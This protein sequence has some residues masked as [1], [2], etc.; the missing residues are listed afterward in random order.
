MGSLPELR[1]RDLS[2]APLAS[3]D[4]SACPTL[5]EN[6]RPV[7]GTVP[8]VRRLQ[9]A[10]I[11]DGRARARL[12][13]QGRDSASFSLQ[14]AAV[15]GG[16][17][18]RVQ[19]P[20]EVDIAPRA[21]LEFRVAFAPAQRGAAAAELV[22]DDQLPQTTTD[23]VVSLVGTG[24]SLPSQPTLET[25]VER[26]GGGFSQCTDTATLSDCELMFPLVAYGSTVSRKVIL[27]NRG[28]GGLQVT[29]LRVVSSL[30]GAPSADF[31]LESPRAP[32]S[33]APLTLSQA[34]GT[35]SLEAVIV[36]APQDQGPGNE[37]RSGFLVVDSNDPRQPPPAQAQPAVLLLRGEGFPSAIAATPSSCDFSRSTDLC[38]SSPKVPNRARFFIRND[39]NGPVRISSATFASTGLA[40][41]S[42]FSLAANAV[43]ATLQP[44]ATLTV[45]VIHTDLPTYVIDEL[46][47]QA[48]FTQNAAPAGSVSLAL[49]GGRQPCLDTPDDVTFTS[50]TPTSTQPVII[51]NQRRLPDGG[52][53]ASSCGT[54]VLSQVR[55]EPSQFFSLTAPLIAPNTQVPAGAFVQSAVQYNR[56][57]SG[58]MQIGK[59]MIVS[60]DPFFGPPL[61][62]KEVNLIAAS[63]FDPPPRAVLKGCVPSMLLNDPNCSIS[64]LELQ[65]TVSLASLLTP[66]SVLVSGF[67]STDFDG[68]T[69]RRPAEYQFRLM[70]PIPAGA[71][72]SSLSP[73]TRGAADRATLMLPGPGLYRVQLQVWDSAGQPSM[74]VNL[75]INVTP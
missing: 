30:P 3:L 61:G 65:M 14:A 10:N 69:T 16:A 70:N 38:G 50:T 24:L 13:F 40:T 29:G 54:L 37:L 53:D 34:D 52:S 75:N 2:G 39:G 33:G 56:P 64:G 46:T 47:L 68:T 5:D 73:N 23:P 20:F 8:D 63:S 17:F 71:S 51:R 66:R 62:T 26:P 48:V 7:S 74:P 6:Q 22:V 58:G 44:G 9:L 41:S 25:G 42:R 57:A 4:T 18:D 72:A 27:R 45:E 31:R 35:S 28:C 43:G 55:V 60:N 12:S 11:G 32:S 1:I 15:D 36:F 49:F 19:T 21:S 59:L 67:D